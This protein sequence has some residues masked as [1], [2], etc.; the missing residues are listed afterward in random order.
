MKKLNEEAIEQL[1]T[2]LKALPE[3][4]K[5]GPFDVIVRLEHELS[6]AQG[7]GYDLDDLMTVLRE[8]GIELARSTVRNYLSRARVQQ[9]KRTR[10]AQ[11]SASTLR[12]ASSQPSMV[13][14]GPNAVLPR[15]NEEA[16]LQPASTRSA[17]AAPRQ[18]KSSS[19]QLTTPAIPEGGRK[20][21]DQELRPGQW[22]MTPDRERL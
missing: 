4:R 14:V 15:G 21:A 6:T 13:D 2:R 17:I 12:S 22:T 19:N 16:L 10:A 3:Q 7:R 8:S 9:R 5:H 11:D 1:S 18:D 20:G